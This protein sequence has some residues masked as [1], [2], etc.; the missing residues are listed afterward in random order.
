MPLLPDHNVWL[1]LDQALNESTLFISMTSPGD[2]FQTCLV[3]MPL[4][5]NEWDVLFN[6]T[7]Q[8][9]CTAPGRLEAVWWC[10]V[11]SRKKEG[12]PAGWYFANSSSQ[13]MNLIHKCPPIPLQPQELDIFGSTQSFLCCFLNYIYGRFTNQRAGIDDIFKQYMMEGYLI[14]SF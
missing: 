3:A 11:D 9:D 7:T 12:Q 2:P 10:K 5:K 14:I 6:I 8:R 1:M 13:G 4:G